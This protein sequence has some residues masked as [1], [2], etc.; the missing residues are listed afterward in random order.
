MLWLWVVMLIKNTEFGNP[1]YNN[2]FNLEINVSPYFV[3][4]YT[5]MDF[6]YMMTEENKIR[7]IDSTIFISSLHHT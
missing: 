4:A 3:I 5:L 1:S 7:S 2:K 6:V